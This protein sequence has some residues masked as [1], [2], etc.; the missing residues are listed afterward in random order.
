MDFGDIKVP[1]MY[2]ACP[3][4]SLLRYL[5]LINKFIEVY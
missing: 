1:E 2:S 3:A 5:R 4:L